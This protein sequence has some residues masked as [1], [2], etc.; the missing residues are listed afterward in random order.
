MPKV[1]VENVP[2]ALLGRANAADCSIS[3]RNSRLSDGAI[4]SRK[5]IVGALHGSNLLRC[6]GFWGETD[7]P[8]SRFFQERI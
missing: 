8:G 1:H 5:T 7:V 2:Y 6:L 4:P 3:K